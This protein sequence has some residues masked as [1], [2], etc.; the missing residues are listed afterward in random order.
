MDVF[1]DGL[2]HNKV[3]INLNRTPPANF[4][5]AVTRTGAEQNLMVK[6]K[7]RGR[8]EV[9]MDICS[10]GG[11][12]PS[13]G[14]R[15]ASIVV[16]QATGKRIAGNWWGRKERALKGGKVPIRKKVGAGHVVAGPP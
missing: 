13:K 16:S 3:A 4:V 15:G 8:E 1:I 7:T 5:D 2:E 14:K 12:V 6:I 10:A 9:P 11:I